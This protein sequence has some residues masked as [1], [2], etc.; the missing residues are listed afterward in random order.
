MRGVLAIYIVVLLLVCGCMTKE[1]VLLPELEQNQNVDLKKCSGFFPKGPWQFI[2]SITFRMAGGHGSTVI[3]V[4]SLDDKEIRCV[5]MT[6]E[7][8]TLFEAV[9]KETEDLEVIR[10]VCPFDREGF[11]QGLLDDVRMIFRPLTVKP[12]KYGM[13]DGHPA[14]RYVKAEVTQDV[15]PVENGQWQIKKY[16]SGHL[17]RILQV[18]KSR[19]QGNTVIPEELTLK[20]WGPASYTLRMKLLESVKEKI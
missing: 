9:E 17:L 18:Y 14:C 19:K 12:A 7:G 11:A 5:L 1:P 2:H 6:L 10:A 4:T 8:L 15:L 13:V 20:A 16:R 3:G